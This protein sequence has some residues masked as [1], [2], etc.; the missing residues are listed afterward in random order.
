MINGNMVGSGAAP[1]KTLIIEDEN[2]NQVTG[3]VTDSL[4]VFDATDND[5]RLGKTY[6]SD[7]GIS[8]G[9]KDIPAYETTK[10]SLLVL[11]GES[12]SVVLDYR[13][14]YDY[15]Q[16]QAIIA[17]FNTS[18]DDSVE[19]EMIVLNDGVYATNS[20]EII[21][22][23]TKNPDIKSIDFNIVN[24]TDEIYVIHYFTYK[25]EI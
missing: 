17:K 7:S 2:G 24:E 16:L 22:E 19:A 18:F 5:V 11:P 6:V 3:V 1:I 15:T 25:E 10:D 8:T 4:V 14:R 13:D 23:I 12:F 21:S 20:T 9:S